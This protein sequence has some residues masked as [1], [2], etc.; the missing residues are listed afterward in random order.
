MHNNTD[1]INTIVSVKHIINN[2]TSINHAISI[3][4]IHTRQ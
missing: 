4:N 3:S 1:I 2:A